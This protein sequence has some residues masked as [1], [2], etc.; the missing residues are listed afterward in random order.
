MEDYYPQF[1]RDNAH[2]N[3][4]AATSYAKRAPVGEVVTN[5]QEK[6][7]SRNTIDNL[8][9]KTKI[10][11][12][13][14]TVSSTAGIATLT[15]DRRHGYN[16]VLG[17]NTITDNTTS[18]ADGTYYNVKLFNGGTAV[19]QGATAKVFVSGGVVA[20]VDIINPGSGYTS[21]ITTLDIES[22]GGDV[23]IGTTTLAVNDGDVVQVTGVGST[24]SKH[25]RIAEV[26]GNVQIALAKTAT[27]PEILPN[28]FV[29]NVGVAVTI[30]SSQY[31]A[32]SGIT[33]FVCANPHDLAVGNKFE[34]L[35]Q[36]D[37]RLGEFTVRERVGIHTFSAV[38]TDEVTSPYYVYRH[39]LEA[40]DQDTSIT[41]EN[42]GRFFAIYAGIHD[43]IVNE[44][45]NVATAI[46]LP[47][48]NNSTTR[49]F[50]LGDYVQVGR[51][52]MR[53]VSSSLGGVS[54]DEITVVRA[55]FGTRAVSHPAGARISKIQPLPVE[56]RRNSILRAS[57]HT[58][59][60]LGYGPG[61]YSTGLPQVQT[62]TLS[63]LEEYLSQAQDRG[64]GIVVYTGLNNDGDFY[65]GNKK[66]NSFT[67]QEETFNVPVPTVTGAEGST[68]SE[69]FEEVVVTNS[70]SVEGGENNNILSNFDGPVRFGGEV[71]ND[72]DVT[73]NG[74]LTLA[75]GF[76]VDPTAALG[77]T[78]TFGNVRI[79][80]DASNK[81][82]VASGQFL[83]GAG[84]GSS[85]G[86]TTDLSVDGDLYV[87]GNITAF[88]PS[89]KNLKDRIQQIAK[90]DQKMKTLS[91]NMFVW[92]E[93][94]GKNKEGQ[95]DY[96]VIAQEVEKEFPE[97][98]VEDKNG[99]KKVR[100]EGLTPVM[101][102]AIKDLIGR[103]EAIEMGS[104]NAPKNPMQMQ[105]PQYPYP[106]PPY[107]YP[108]PPQQPPQEPQQ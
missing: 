33:T 30:S 19:W 62:R 76:T 42:G 81:V 6:S 108:Y 55:M 21:G 26:N 89:D 28:S 49:R 12:E 104:P 31:D 73:I 88:F 36:S 51:E 100:Y 20:A 15:F 45:T 94:A 4:P 92:N 78:P 43:Q 101:I 59:E 53:V 5:E 44:L 105:M 91:G 9:K 72:G 96:G 25:Y 46:K 87:T 68:T 75:G 37:G 35:N 13:V 90:P 83:V 52:I 3:P 34:L 93:K 47:N 69:R 103:V 7:I 58:F 54:S 48:V 2:S 23:G 102:E 86:V 8:F 67:G 38:T 1:D 22:I 82:D 18:Y 77:I 97:L 32:P 16:G 65:I 60:Y 70:I 39:A 85:V 14:S 84:M 95:I 11:K 66:I 71:T 63:D 27:D 107:P 61:N 80:V 106:Y 41:E 29:Y 40:N 56:L 57:G 10:G 50:A 99:V 24:A 98:V 17:I 79:A 74:N 64:G